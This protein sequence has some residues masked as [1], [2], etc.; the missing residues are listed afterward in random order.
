MPTQN[1]NERELLKDSIPFSHHQLKE[2]SENHI[3]KWIRQHLE[4]RLKIVEDDMKL[5]P[6]VQQV[7]LGV[8][9]EYSILHGIDHYQGE[10]KG[11]SYIIGFIELLPEIKS[12]ELERDEETTK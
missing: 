8:D 9:N 2:F 10:H 4:D 11:L 6:A 7:R 1:L 5:C 3:W 12:E